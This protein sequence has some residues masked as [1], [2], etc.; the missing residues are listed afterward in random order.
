MCTRK[1]DLLDR[2]FNGVSCRW[3]RS[4]PRDRNQQERDAELRRR[5][6]NSTMTDP[7]HGLL[8]ATLASS[9]A[10]LLLLVLR[11][12]MRRIFGAPAAYA[13]WMLVPLASG[14]ALLP[15]PV[16]TVACRRF[17]LRLR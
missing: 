9:A 8:V 7:L 2:L 11:K 13:L 14:A 15:V 1:Q 6:R 10:I 17:R 5:S 3:S 16:K 4:F 12:P